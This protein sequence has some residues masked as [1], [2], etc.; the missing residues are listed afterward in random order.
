MQARLLLS[1]LWLL[2]L[3]PVPRSQAQ[4]RLLGPWRLTYTMQERWVHGPDTVA[5]EMVRGWE[6]DW[7]YHEVRWDVEPDSI[8]LFLNCENPLIAPPQPRKGQLPIRFTAT[9]ATVRLDAKTHRL[10][11][12]P[13]AT[14]VTLWAYRGRALVFK[15]QFIAITPPLPKVEGSYGG[16]MPSDLRPG[17]EWYRQ[18]FLRAVPSAEFSSFMPNDAHYRVSQYQVSFLR[19]DVLIR[20]TTTIKSPSD[21]IGLKYCDLI[22]VDVQLVQR[23]NF[24]GVVETLPLRKRIMIKVQ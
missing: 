21:F 12:A 1:A 20:P 18:L 7:S 15:H 24:R 3:L 19:N 4:G 5:K 6:P 13:T 8:R 11:I 9:G 22:Q 16:A 10:L 2:S 23:Q 14:T 17:E